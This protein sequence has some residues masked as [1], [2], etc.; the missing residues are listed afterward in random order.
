MRI[1][2]YMKQK[3]TYSQYK[4]L[5]SKHLNLLDFFSDNP[6]ENCIQRYFKNDSNNPN[7]NITTKFIEFTYNYVFNKILYKEINFIEKSPSQNKC[8]IHLINKDEK[9]IVTSITKLKEQLSP[10]FFQTHKSCLVNLNNIKHID[11]AKFTIYF[12]NGE[13]INLLTPSARKEL[14]QFVGN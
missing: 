1:V 12:K 5:T 13:S 9:H 2:L 3:N 8:I 10:I 7:E 4:I 14:K 11:Y 6:Y